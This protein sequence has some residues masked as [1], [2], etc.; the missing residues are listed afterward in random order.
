LTGPT[1]R[2]ADTAGQLAVALTANGDEL[3]FTIFA[4]GFQ[5]PGRLRLTAEAHRPGGTSRLLYSRS[6]GSGCFATRLPLQRG[7]TVVTANVSS[8]DWRGG[9]VRFTIPWPLAPQQPALIRRVAAAMRAVR[10]LTLTEQLS[11]AYG[12]TQPPT[13]QSLSGAQFMRT[14]VF[15]SDAVDVRSLGAQNGLQ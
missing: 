9:T 15:D 12:R 4:F 6:C 7:S 14:A 11:L 1:L 5:P 8:S 2:L 3:Q 10:S 13:T